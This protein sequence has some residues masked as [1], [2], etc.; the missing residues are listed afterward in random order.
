[1]VQL[2]LVRRRVT[3]A[4]F[5]RLNDEKRNIWFS[6][7]SCSGALVCICAV[8]TRLCTTGIGL[9]E[10]SVS[11]MGGAGSAVSD[12]CDEYLRFI[13]SAKKWTC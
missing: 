4:N 6:L 1:M 12:A 3:A 8:A 5:L 10:S 7:S 2:G 11:A 9:S 13:F